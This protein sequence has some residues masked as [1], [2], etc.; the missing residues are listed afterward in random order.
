MQWFNNLR[1]IFWFRF[2]IGKKPIGIKKITEIKNVKTN[3]KK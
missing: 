2:K 3:Q 1:F